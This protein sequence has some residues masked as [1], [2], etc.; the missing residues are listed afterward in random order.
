MTDQRQKVGIAKW[1]RHKV[2]HAGG[3]AGLGI[4]GVSIGGEGDDTTLAVLGIPFTFACNI[5]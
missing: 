4:A 2:I 3:R 1:L 5:G